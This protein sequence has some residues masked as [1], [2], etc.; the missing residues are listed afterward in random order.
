[1]PHFFNKKEL[2]QQQMENWNRYV[3]MYEKTLGFNVNRQLIQMQNEDKKKFVEMFQ[4]VSQAEI[5]EKM[6]QNAQ[7]MGNFPGDEKSALFFRLI[8]GKKP[9]LYRVPLSYSYPDYDIMEN[10]NPRELDLDSLSMNSMVK[11]QKL[12]INQCSW[13]VLKHTDT[14]AEVT[15]GDWEK[16]GFVWSVELKDLKAQDS[17][18]AIIS[19]HNPDLIKITTYEELLKETEFQVRNDARK[20]LIHLYSNEAQ[21]MKEE[22]KRYGS[23]ADIMYQQEELRG[24]DMLA[25]RREKN[26]TDYPTEKEIQKMAEELIPQYLGKDYYVS[27]N[28]LYVKTWVMEKLNNKEMKPEYYLE[29]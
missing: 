18:K 21:K 17:Q 5:Q 16:L 1:M 29:I 28:Q 10:E 25:K 24:K 6:I 26:L 3:D 11:N 2:T 13:K 27:D 15:F 14:Y 4:D 23:F 20:I 9:F 7:L 12:S 19:H 22:Y 8:S